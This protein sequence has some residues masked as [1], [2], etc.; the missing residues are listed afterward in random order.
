MSE[1]Y[2]PK[3]LIDKYRDVLVCHDDWYDNVYEHFKEMMSVI[4]IQVIRIQFSGFWSQGDGACFDGRIVDWG[5]YLLHLGYDNLILHQAAEDN[6]SFSWEQRGRYCHEHSVLYDDALW[7]P[8]NPYDE[9]EEP[10]RHDTWAN[11]L[12]TYDFLAITDEMKENL[13]GHMRSLYRTLEQEYDDLT[14][15]ETVSAWMQDNYIE[16]TELEI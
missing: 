6:W 3:D 7:R 13:R 9:D 14:S 1:L 15:D 10:L 16:L 11:T 4:G 5:K 8:K 12:E 2:Y